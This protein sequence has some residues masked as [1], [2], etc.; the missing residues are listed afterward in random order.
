MKNYKHYYQPNP[1]TNKTYKKITRVS[2]H[3][4]ILTNHI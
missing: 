2:Y 4:T 3:Y 1:K